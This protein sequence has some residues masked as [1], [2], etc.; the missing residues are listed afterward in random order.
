MSNIP[1]ARTL[2]TEILSTY[3]LRPKARRLL[4]K[5]LREMTRRKPDFR[6][7]REYKRLNPL[8][9]RQA[10]TLRRKGYSLAKI[11]RRIGI[12]NTGRISEAVNGRAH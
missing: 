11:A 12:G 7:S 5:A 9:R 1:L 6:H 10:R 2:L 3:K 4:L 8:E